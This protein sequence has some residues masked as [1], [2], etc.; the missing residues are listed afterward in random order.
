MKEREAVQVLAVAASYDARRASTVEAQT[1]A[2]ELR[3]VDLVDAIAA[4][5]EHYRVRP[6]DRIRPGHVLT[7]LADRRR[8]RLANVSRLEAAALRAIDPDDP[9]YTAKA[10]RALADARQRAAVDPDAVPAH[11]LPAREETAEE[12]SDRTRRGKSVVQAELDKIAAVKAASEPKIDP[13]VSE[14]LQRA[15]ELARQ[16]KRDRDHP[17]Q[18]P[19]KPLAGTVGDNPDVLVEKFKQLRERTAE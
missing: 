7:I 3:D 10:Q 5:R 18:G 9:E 13:N 4:V 12:R 6:D 8:H 19:P 14:T 17:P 16:Y 11:V 2:Y 15:R 1:W